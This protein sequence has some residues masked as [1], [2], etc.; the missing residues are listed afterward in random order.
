MTKALSGERSIASLDHSFN[1]LSTLYDDCDEGEEIQLSEI[2]IELES[3]RALEH[4][5]HTSSAIAKH[6][7]I[8]LLSLDRLIT[9]RVAERLAYYAIPE[10]IEGENESGLL[11]PEL[12]ELLRKHYQLP[13]VWDEDFQLKEELA[14]ILA[15]VDPD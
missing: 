3:A 2:A 10:E 8:K 4:R 11:A 13:D 9:K 15:L 6:L 1:L 14:K 12:T 5:V 7:E